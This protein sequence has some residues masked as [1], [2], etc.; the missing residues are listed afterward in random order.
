VNAPVPWC[1]GRSSD[2]GLVFPVVTVTGQYRYYLQLNTATA[3]HR[4]FL[5]LRTSAITRG[6]VH[7]YDA[8]TLELEESKQSSWQHPVHLGLPCKNSSR[9]TLRSY[10][11]CL[12]WPV[13]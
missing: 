10:A 6:S 7:S 8:T 11:S 2:R 4:A 5:L 9:L 1:C 13:A 3:Y 12:V